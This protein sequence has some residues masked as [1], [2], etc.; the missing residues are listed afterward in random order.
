M[1]V[2]QALSLLL[3]VI[4]ILIFIRVIV[5]WLPIGRDNPF[6]RTLYLL[7]EPI[8][9][10]IRRLVEKSPIGANM[11]FDFSPLIVW[12]VIRVIRNIFYI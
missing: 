6:I 9:E 11:M 7:T 5:S 3:T 10:P 12:L 8:L 4:E 2:K 1:L